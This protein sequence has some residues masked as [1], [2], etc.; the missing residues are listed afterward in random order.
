[1]NHGEI[2][3]ADRAQKSANP[4]RAFKLWVSIEAIEQDRDQYADLAALGF[5]QPVSLGAYSS[6]VEAVKWLLDLPGCQKDERDEALLARADA[7]EREIWERLSALDPLIAKPSP[8]ALV[9][10][11]LSGVDWKL[12]RAQKRSL[13][14][15]TIKKG[16]GVKRRHRKALSGILHLLDHIQDEATRQLGGAVVFGNPD[17]AAPH[18]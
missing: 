8:L 17:N 5:I 16:A 9:S 4:A 11:D 18:D 1:M 12:L 6:L 13:A 2:S 14:R 15:L 7:I 3:L 10:A